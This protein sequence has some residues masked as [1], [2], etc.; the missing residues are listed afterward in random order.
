MAAIKAETMIPQTGLFV[1]QIFGVDKVLVDSLVN[2][3]LAAQD[4]ADIGQRQHSHE[5]RIVPQLA[6]VD[7]IRCDMLE[8][9]LARAGQAVHGPLGPLFA[10]IAV[11]FILGVLV[12]VAQG[13]N[14][15][16]RVDVLAGQALGNAGV[17]VLGQ[18]IQAA[19]VVLFLKQ[20]PQAVQA[21][22]LGPLP[23]HIAG[24]VALIHVGFCHVLQ[25]GLVPFI[26]DR[27]EALNAKL[28]LVFN[29]SFLHG[30]FLL[31]YYNR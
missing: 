19:L 29:I 28:Q 1:S 18:H 24:Q 22:A 23:Q 26:Q 16:H 20:L 3:V 4:A 2:V 17:V 7:A 9:A 14:G 8:A 21:H 27:F 25:E 30:G 10:D 5:Q 6:I 11:L 31:F 12:Q 15:G 13:K